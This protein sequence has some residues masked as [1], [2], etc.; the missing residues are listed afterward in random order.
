MSVK[1]DG[2][3]INPSDMYELNGWPSVD[4]GS[5]PAIS[6]DGRYVA[7]QTAASLV[8]ADTGTSVD[9]S[10]IGRLDVYVYDRQTHTVDLVSQTPAGTAAGGVMFNNPSISAHGRYVTF[11][12]LGGSTAL[13]T[14]KSGV[15]YVYVRDRL[16]HRT[17]ALLDQ[18][19]WQ[20]EISADGQTV[21][22]SDLSNTKAPTLVAIDLTTGDTDRIDV[23]TAGDPGVES[24]FAHIVFTPSVSEDGRYVGFKSFAWNLIPGRSGP[25]TNYSGAFPADLVTAYVRDRQAR[26]TTV[27]PTTYRPFYDGPVSIADGGGR[28]AVGSWGGPEQLVEMPSGPVGTYGLAQVGSTPLD[29]RIEMTRALS[30][31]GRYV[32]FGAEVFPTADIY[33]Q[34]VG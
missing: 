26:T 17:M 5:H 25:L 15:Q 31:D 27:V 19:A 20:P 3:Q 1:A 28:I 29:N 7:F 33:I 22:V 14:Q 2:S 24:Q 21:V 11:T 9:N 10:G 6:A 16:M 18:P 32:A 8:P 34:R 4:V 23:T 12:V 13:T 30:A